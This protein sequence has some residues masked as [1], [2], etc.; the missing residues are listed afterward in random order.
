MTLFAWESF[1]AL[2]LLLFGVPVALFLRQ[3]EVL[4]LIGVMVLI[5]FVPAVANYS[6]EARHALM[7]L[8]RVAHGCHAKPPD[9]PH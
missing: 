5:T 3:P 1:T 7:A 2:L 8:R 6:T 9:I 4:V